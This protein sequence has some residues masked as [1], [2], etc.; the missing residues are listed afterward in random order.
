[1]LERVGRNETKRLKKRSHVDRKLK[2]K[3]IKK[4]NFACG[5]L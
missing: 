3:E 4:G 5:V 2:R 1:M